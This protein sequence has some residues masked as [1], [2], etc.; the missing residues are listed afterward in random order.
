MKCAEFHLQI[1]MLLDGALGPEEEAETIAHAES[2]PECALALEKEQHFHSFLRKRLHP[3]PAPAALRKLVMNDMRAQKNKSFWRWPAVGTGLL[4]AAS[5]AAFF[6]IG[7]G[8][9]QN[10]LPGTIKTAIARQSD[11][12][13]PLDVNSANEA[14]LRA[15]FAGHLPFEFDLPKISTGT[16]VRG[17]RLTYLGEQPTAFISYEINGTPASLY[18][19]TD[20]NSSEYVRKSPTKCQ[21]LTADGTEREAVVWQRGNVVYSLISRKAEPLMADFIKDGCRK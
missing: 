14:D 16:H 8:A 18:V 1:P 7:G 12:R 4:A 17:G 15:F 9:G 2:C 11:D 19:F 5:I 6:F 3:A 13:L 21:V 20:R 10:Q